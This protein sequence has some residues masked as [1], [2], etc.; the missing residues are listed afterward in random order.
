M[1]EERERKGWGMLGDGLG[2][3]ESGSKTENADLSHSRTTS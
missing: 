3:Y 2:G 1:A